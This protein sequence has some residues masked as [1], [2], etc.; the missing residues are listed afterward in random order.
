VAAAAPTASFAERFAASRRG[1]AGRG[2]GRGVGRAAP[3][4]SSA[5]VAQQ[6]ISVAAAPTDP[7]VVSV[8]DFGAVGDGTTDNTPA[9]Q[10]ALTSL[11]ATGGTV[12]V[13]DGNFSF[14]GS[15]V[16]PSAV[17]LQGTFASV[18]SHDVAQGAPIPNRGSIL[19]VRGGRGDAAGT[20]FMT[21][22]GDCAVR[23][24]VFYYP[25]NVRGQVPAAY[26]YSI[27]L[28]GNNPAV[29]DVELLN[30]F[31][32]ISAVGAARHYIARVQGQPANVGIFIDQTYDIGRVEVRTL[33]RREASGRGG[34]ASR[35][36]A[37]CPARSPADPLHYPTRLT[38]QDVHWNP[39]WDASPAYVGYQINFGVGFLIAR[40]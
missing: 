36:R 13:P 39:W 35:V 17:A 18:P 5:T 11:A 29:E 25:E 20:P 30:P 34:F 26:P 22:V 16:F 38:P 31:N 24:L 10:A 12:L 3:R 8:L 28:T 15:L 33:W 21:L 9:F 32:G 27:A 23:G 40:T 4:A 19:L 37:H 14:S 2:A 7:S 1:G 6:R